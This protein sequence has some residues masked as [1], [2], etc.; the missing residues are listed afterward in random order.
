MGK[1]QQQLSPHSTILSRLMISYELD[2]RSL[3]LFFF[4]AARR[5][6]LTTDTYV[7]RDEGSGRGEALVKLVNH[8]RVITTTRKL[9]IPVT[10]GVFP[11]RNTSQKKESNCFLPPSLLLFVLSKLSFIHSFIHLID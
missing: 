9:V 6:F 3:K 7:D 10:V 1:Q 5:G 2:E 4:L 8:S 11:K